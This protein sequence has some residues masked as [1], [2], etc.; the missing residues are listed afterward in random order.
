[1]NGKAEY[2]SLAGTARAMG[3]LMVQGARLGMG[4]LGSYLPRR[5]E[6][7]GC[8]I[9]PACWAPQPLG[10]VASRACPGD[11]A[12]VRLTITN[13]G[14]A[15]RTVKVSATD[16]AVV[17]EP[18]ALALGAMEEG[19]AVL[20]LKV[21]PGAHVGETRK[22]TVWVRGCKEHVLRWRVEVVSRGAD[23]LAEV[24]IEDCPDLVHHWYD[25]FY[26]RRPCPHRG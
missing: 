8:E 15:A 18:A 12:V 19:V 1:M 10:Q 21:A 6:G 7:C 11:T 17:V 22:L 2:G 3:D 26:C 20:S 9:P 14:A 23:C 25:H 13:C 4:L 24:E 5:N 16:P